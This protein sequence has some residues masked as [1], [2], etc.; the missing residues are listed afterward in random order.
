MSDT[1]LKLLYNSL[2]LPYLMYC[3]IVWCST[4]L[5]YC[6]IVWCSTY[7]THLSKLFILQKQSIRIITNSSYNAHTNIL[8]F[9]LQILNVYNIFKLQLGECMYKYFNRYLLDKLGNYFFL[10][11][12]VHSHYSR[13]SNLSF[14]FAYYYTS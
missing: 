1:V 14:I 8:F 2:I 11:S 5:M 9:H 13:S 4:Y 10:N 12:D 7:P 3:N 6:N